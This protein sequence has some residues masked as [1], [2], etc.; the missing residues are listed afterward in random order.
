MKRQ[1]P[2]CRE[3]VDFT[4]ASCAHCQLGFFKTPEAH[5]DIN[6]ICL[7]IGGGMLLAA[8]GALVALMLHPWA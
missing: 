5:K 6:D 4:V 2:R 3:T 8:V 1:C 7:K